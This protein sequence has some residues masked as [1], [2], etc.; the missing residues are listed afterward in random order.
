MQKL[1]NSKHGFALIELLIV[2]AIIA[3]LAAIAVPNFQEAQT[4]AQIS[5]V[6][7][8]T[9]SLAVALESYFVDEAAYPV[10]SDPNGDSVSPELAT[11]SGFETRIPVSLTTPIA[12][13]RT[14]PEDSF[15]PDYPV[16]SRLFHYA[17]MDYFLAVEGSADSFLGFV[18]SAYE[19]AATTA[20][21]FVLSQGPDRDRDSGSGHANPSG[22]VLYDPTNGTLSS[23]DIV[24]WGPTTGLRN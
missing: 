22:A 10:P 2:V 9:R 5:A 11:A 13:F 20:T 8:D 21:Y 17:T 18:L 12:Y 19:P 7:S 4:R 23:G 14:R 15:V 1:R 24:Y 6:K 16:Q 3:V